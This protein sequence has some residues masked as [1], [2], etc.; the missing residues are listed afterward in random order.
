MTFLDE[1]ESLLKEEE[2]SQNSKC[3]ATYGKLDPF[4]LAGLFTVR[5]KI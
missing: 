2:T 4:G 3:Y 5:A 1:V